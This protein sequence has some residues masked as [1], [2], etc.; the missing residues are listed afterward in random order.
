MLTL[1]IVTRLKSLRCTR[2]LSISFNL[3]DCNVEQQSPFMKALKVK[4][5]IYSIYSKSIK[6]RLY[7]T[8]YWVVL[9]TI[10]RQPE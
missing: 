1:H 9:E 10:Y 6:C 7:R 8:I 2:T 4:V 3:L 5:H